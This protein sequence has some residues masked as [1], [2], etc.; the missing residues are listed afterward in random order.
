MTLT[1]IYGEIATVTNS[2]FNNKNKYIVT[3]INSAISVKN[4]TDEHLLAEHREIKRLPQVYLKSLHANSINNIP[5]KS[6][7][8]EGHV[9]FFI[10]K[11]TFTLNRYK[12]LYKECIN[13]G[14]NVQ[15]YSANWKNVANKLYWNDYKPTTEE[16][17]LLI[18]RICERI[19]ESKKKCFHYDGETITKSEAIELLNK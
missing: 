6:C 19:A 12:E 13:R 4:L 5:D 7:L 16:H 9:K 10:N 2:T 3:R 15:D 18:K 1:D 8:G 14:F 17:D 11:N